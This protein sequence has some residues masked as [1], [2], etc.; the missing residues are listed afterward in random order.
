M[1]K[2]KSVETNLG[3]AA[4]KCQAGLTSLTVNAMSPSISLGPVI[5]QVVNGI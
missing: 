3:T 1:T 5:G 4:A 2:V